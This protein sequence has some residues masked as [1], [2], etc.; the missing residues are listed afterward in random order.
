[1]TNEKCKKCNKRLL[2]VTLR[3]LISKWKDD[4][5]AVVYGDPEDIKLVITEM[6]KLDNSE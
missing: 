3:T 2:V 6:D 5:E 1:M 4:L